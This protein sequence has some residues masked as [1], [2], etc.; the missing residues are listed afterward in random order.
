MNRDAK[1]YIISLRLTEKDHSQLMEMLQQENSRRDPSLAK[2][3]VSSLM[4]D[5]LFRKQEKAD[6][7]EAHRLVQR[8]STDL[9]H[10]LLRLERRGNTE[11]WENLQWAAEQTIE[12]IRKWR[13]QY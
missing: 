4:R 1:N 2:S 9:E 8:I 6:L 7:S 11:D 5:L 13:S 3:T 10:A 12:R